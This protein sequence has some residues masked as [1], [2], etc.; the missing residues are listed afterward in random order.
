[1]LYPKVQNPLS[2]L[3]L[4]HSKGTFTPALLTLFSQNLRFIGEV[5]M[6]NETLIWTKQT[7]SSL[8]K[9]VDLDSM[10]TNYAALQLHV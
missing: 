3:V 5:C 9:N 1:M 8:P 7:N 10:K 6:G 4:I 2:V